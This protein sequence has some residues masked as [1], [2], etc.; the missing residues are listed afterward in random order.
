MHTNSTSLFR[1]AGVIAVTSLVLSSPLFAATD[2]S[3]AFPTFDSYLKI[4]GQAASI[5]GDGAAY[6]SRY[7]Q[8]E[9]AGAGI[10]DFHYNRDL[11]KESTMTLDGR[12]LTGSEDYLFDL[13]LTKT[14]VGS[15]D[16]GY[17]RFRTFYD[18]VGGFFPGNGKFYTISQL[19]PN[20]PEDLFVDRG[21]FWAEVKIARP[22]APEV[23]VRYTNGTRNGLKDSTIWGETQDTGI[24]YKVTGLPGTT[25]TINNAAQR[26]IVPSYLDIDER[27]QTLDCTVKQTFG[28]TL[29][30]ISVLGD[31][32]SINNSRYATKYPGGAMAVKVNPGANNDTLIT[33]TTPGQILASQWST[34]GNQVQ[35]TTFDVQDS[36]TKGVTGS[37]VTELSSKLTLRLAASYQDVTNDFSGDRVLVTTTPQGAD[38][39]TTLIQ[40]YYD[41]KDLSGQSNAQV[42]AGSATLDFKPIE[43]VTVSPW[44]RVE[45]RDADSDGKYKV[46]AATSATNPTAGA[47][48]PRVEASDVNEKSFTPG[49]DL[50]YTGFKDLALYSR[51]SH[52]FG[53]GDEV[54]T[55]AYN[56]LTTVLPLTYYNDIIEDRNECMIGANWRASSSLTLRGEPFFKDSTYHAKG[57]NTNASATSTPVASTFGNNYQLE[58]KFWG[59]KLTAIVKPL[60]VLTFTTR[61]IF[62]RGTMQVTGFLPTL[63]AYDSMESTSHTIGET[64]DWNPI[65][66]FYM[67]VS[68]DVVFNQISTAYQHDQSTAAANAIPANLMIQNSDNNYITFSAL[69]GFVVTK[70]DDIQIQFTY[71]RADNSN[72]RLASYTVP[73]GSD[74]TEMIVSVGLKHKISDRCICSGKIGYVDSHNGTTG[75]NTDFHGPLAYVSLDYGL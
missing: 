43:T 59:A 36:F 5:K 11:S 27:H 70:R 60:N 16:V 25:G 64:I 74:A 40:N 14:E 56:N 63:P 3:D 72:S 32:S 2:K 26:K 39:G 62:Q 55:P 53:T 20:V 10:E 38:Y 46:I 33:P 22:D 71:Y 23:T 17:K 35:Q 57:Y 30:Q 41:F 9:N 67:Q 21:E 51:A 48:T 6:Q 52:K 31:W 49:L 73:Y 12:A 54:V 45:D 58:S 15:V 44:F 29:A 28:K 7:R 34:F 37:T 19:Y 75:G 47:P 61:Y 1:P 50:R 4:S 66:Q 8:D 13:K 18:G 24:N 68:A 69:A 42:A 65:E